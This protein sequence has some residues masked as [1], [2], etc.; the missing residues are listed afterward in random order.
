MMFAVIALVAGCRRSAPE[1]TTPLRQRGY[2][3]QREWNAAVADS[4]ANARKKMDGV[5]ILG[6]EIVWNGK[7]PEVVSAT[8]NWEMLKEADAPC[9]IALRIAPGPI[10]ED[11]TRT[12]FIV[13][14]VQAL[15]E[16]MRV[17]GVTLQEFQLDFDCPQKDLQSYR[18]LVQTLRSLLRPVRLVITT[19]PSWLDEPEFVP[20]AREADGYVLQVHSVPTSNETGRA[21]LCDVRLARKWAAKAASFGMPFSVALPTY[22]CSA[23]YNREGKLLSIAMDSVQPA[24]PPDTRILEFETN[25]DEIADLVKEWQHNRPAELREIIWYRLP[26]ATDTRNWRWVTLLKVMSGERPVHK[27][28]VLQEGENPVDLSVVN[29]GEADERLDSVVTVTWSGQTLVAADALAGWMVNPG[30]EKAVF[31]ITPGFRIR[32]SPGGKREIGWLRHDQSTILRLQLARQNE[33][34]H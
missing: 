19:L 31:T 4:L 5:V 28:E 34:A 24:W 17:H 7:G 30:K 3:W 9:S 29:L 25:P 11:K 8:I 32:L 22:R 1:S 2:I 6:S 14:A 23:G 33:A 13:A 12:R 21:S 16:Q 18:T 26:V 10:F 20:L 15:L 27:L